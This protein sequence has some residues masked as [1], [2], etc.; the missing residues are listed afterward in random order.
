MLLWV[1]SLV[2]E[3]AQSINVVTWED[4]LEPDGFL[5]RR[6]YRFLSLGWLEP[7]ENRQL[8]ES[9]GFTIEACY[10]AFDR[11][12][13]HDRTAREQVWVARRPQ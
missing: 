8:L 4:Q 5:G 12:P 7:A 10:G 9:A 3:A 13:F 11:T 2:D 1:T 6:Q